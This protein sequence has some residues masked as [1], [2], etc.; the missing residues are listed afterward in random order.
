MAR[1][2]TIVYRGYDPVELEL[3]ETQ[4]RAA[5]M[6]YVRIG[7]G[8]AAMLGVGNYIVEQLIEVPIECFDEARALVAAARGDDALADSEDSDELALAGGESDEPGSTSPRRVRGASFREQLIGAGLSLLFPGLGTAYA[9]YPLPGFAIAGWAFVVW[10]SAA[11][12]ETPIA[13]VLVSQLFARAA[14]LAVTQVRL[15]RA[16]RTR[17]SVFAQVLVAALCIAGLQSVLHY[18]RNHEPRELAPL[19]A[20]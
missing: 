20:R 14:E 8:T 10:I 7:R 9:G 6:P 5:D 19:R 15:L 18:A 4:L 12:A 2:H 17:P 1:S 16:G 11:Q 13:N 3:I